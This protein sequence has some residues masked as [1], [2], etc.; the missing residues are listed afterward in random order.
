MGYYPPK[1][2]H[3]PLDVVGAGLGV[4]LLMTHR[5]DPWEREP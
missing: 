2:P 5:F 3:P 4:L 1:D